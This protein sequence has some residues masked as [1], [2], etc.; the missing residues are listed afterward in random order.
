MKSIIEK[1]LKNSFVVCVLILGVIFVTTI[2]FATDVKVKQGAITA[3]KVDSLAAPTDSND[4]ANKDYV[5]NNV[6]AI[7]SIL[8]SWTSTD[9]NSTTLAQ[10]NVYKAES[11]GFVC[12]RTAALNSNGGSIAGYT[13]GSNPPTTL[14]SYCVTGAVYGAHP[15]LNFTMPVKKDDYWK[16]AEGGDGTPTILWVPIGNSDC[17]KQ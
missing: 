4:A 10:N 9:S 3:T 6:A 13:D 7:D 11:D 2:V 14:R 5:D 15:V 8:G 16:V 12:V 1:M 17:V